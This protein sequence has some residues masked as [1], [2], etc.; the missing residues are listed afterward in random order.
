LVA[1]TCPPPPADIIYDETG[2]VKAVVKPG[3]NAE[4]AEYA[5]DKV[6]NI[7]AIT[8]HP[9]SQV[10]VVTWTPRCAAPSASPVT[11]TI[12]GSGF[13]ST[14]ANNQVTVGGIPVSSVVSA[15][16]VRLVVTT[17]A[18]GQIRVAVPPGGTNF[19]DTSADG[20]TSNCGG[21]PTITSVSTPL[22]SV[23]GGTF[24]Y[25][26]NFSPL[27]LN[28]IVRFN[29]SPATVP[30]ADPAPFPPPPGMVMLVFV[31]SGATSG[32]MSLRTPQGQVVS[33]FDAYVAPEGMTAGQID[34]TGRLTSG[35]PTTV[36]I[37]QNDHAGLRILDLA[38]GERV[39]LV[40]G[41]GSL[42][43]PYATLREPDGTTVGTANLFVEPVTVPGG[44]TYTYLVRS[45][46][47]QRPVRQPS[48]DISVLTGG[49]WRTTRAEIIPSSW[50]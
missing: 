35:V 16:S 11:L 14:P 33:T 13:S 10:S 6:G 43:L 12:E 32:R 4:T 41:S 17:S 22:L 19:D 18:R 39:S 34:S 2:R 21:A 27:R 50:S 24:V 37:V 46:L 5:Y 15:S 8:R 1:Q 7:T 44:G 25:G 40:Y 49:E 31:P 38:A 30:V 47:C 42:P 28:N 23:G 26:T 36:T 3:A 9:S 48:L 45:P 20:L 29:V